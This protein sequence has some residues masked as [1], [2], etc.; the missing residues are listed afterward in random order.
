MKYAKFVILKLLKLPNYETTQ[1]NY[2]RQ[3]HIPL[4]HPF[5]NHT[6]NKKQHKAYR[7]LTIYILYLDSQKKTHVSVLYIF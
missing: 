7:I 4:L 5:F 2:N 6:L 3:K 1:Q